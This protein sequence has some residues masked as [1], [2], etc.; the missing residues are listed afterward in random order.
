M[1][2]AGVN[3]TIGTDSIVCQL[4]DEAQPLG[5]MAQVRRLYRR[6][7]M[8]P[9]VLLAMATTHGARALQLPAGAATLQPGAPAKLAAVPFNPDD[10]CDPWVQALSHDRPMMPITPIMSP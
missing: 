6:D 5:V 1:L 9:A 7:R 4:P 2:D 10:A 3:V 8:L